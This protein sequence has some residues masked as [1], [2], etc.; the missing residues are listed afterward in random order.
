MTKVREHF[1]DKA[2]VHSVVK[3]REHCDDSVMEQ[4]DE[5]CHGTF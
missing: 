1:D 4:F 5:K 2:V 3:G